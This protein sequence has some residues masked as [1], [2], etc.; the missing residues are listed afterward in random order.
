[1]GKRSSSERENSGK[2]CSLTA[3][4]V[5]VTRLRTAS[6]GAT[7]GTGGTE[8]TGTGAAAAQGPGS[9]NSQHQQRMEEAHAAPAKQRLATKDLQAPRVEPVEME[10]AEKGLV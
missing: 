6:R 4:N 9:K 10:L 3:R 5:G 1:M 7:A 8:T 2:P